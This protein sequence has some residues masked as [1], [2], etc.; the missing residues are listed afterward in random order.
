MKTII[1]LL[2]LILTVYNLQSIYYCASPVMYS[3]WETGSVAQTGTRESECLGT[4]RMDE[5]GNK[6][7]KWE[8]SA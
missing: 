2:L 8:K 7:R 1:T 3:R 6:G 4:G 5:W